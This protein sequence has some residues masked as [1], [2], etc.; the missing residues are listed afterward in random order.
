MY[1][2]GKII[3]GLIIF[4]GLFT[5]PMWYD[6]LNGKAALKEPDLVLP[7]NANQKE[8]VESKEYMRSNHMVLL[9]DWRFEVVRE[10]KRIFVG[11]YNKNFD[12]SLTSTCLDCHSN[13][14]Q[15]CDQ[16]HNYA[17]ITPYCWDCH[18]EFQKPG[19]KQ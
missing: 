13:G 11:N 4:V 10:G 2:S 3:A 12:M 1:N 17:G 19:S 8:C 18:T 15:F 5:S 7:S 14:S 16:C 6:L 9:N